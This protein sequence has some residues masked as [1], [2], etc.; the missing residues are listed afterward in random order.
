[1]EL[2]ATLCT[3]RS[4]ECLLCPVQQFCE[5]RKLGIAGELP[6]KR[7]KRA[8]VAVRLAAAVFLDRSRHSLLLLPPAGSH[9]S[10]ADDHVPSLVA[11]LWHFPTTPANGDVATAVRQLLS[12]QLQ[13]RNWTALKCEPLAKVRHTVTYRKI[14]LA[15]FLI[16]VKKLP[17]VSGGKAIEL[18]EILEQPISNL[19]RKVARAALKRLAGDP[20]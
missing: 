13:V 2:G 16:R 1:M 5:A 14:E 19:T 17:S 11:N 18:N 12:Q 7:E 8:G 4:P 15:P 6:E 20:A 9:Q 10:G 3:P